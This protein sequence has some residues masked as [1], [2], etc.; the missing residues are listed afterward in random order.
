[1]TAPRVYSKMAVERCRMYLAQLHA[2]HYLG[3][4]GRLENTIQ[5]DTVAALLKGLGQ[6]LDV[7][8]ALIDS[9]DR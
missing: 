4:E 1:M 9:H 8:E 7:L 3:A 6:D 5:D 2:A